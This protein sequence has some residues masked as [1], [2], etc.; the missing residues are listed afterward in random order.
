MEILIVDDTVENIKLVSDLLGDF[1]T[2]FARSG[3]EALKL[4]EEEH[5]DLILLDVMM[6]GLDGYETCQ[7]L[8]QMPNSAE[9]PVIF[10]T[11]KTDNE[12]IIKAFASGGQD[13]LSKPFHTEELRAR[14]K[15]QLISKRYQD[16]LKQQ[17]HLEK[18]KNRAQELNSELEGTL[19]QLQK[20]WQESFE[21]TNKAIQ[22]LKSD[23]SNLESELRV[24]SDAL[25]EFNKKIE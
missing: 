19:S 24:I 21:T 17:L 12:S 2:S 25:S 8:R 15:N 5:F 9:T 23:A 18:D 20:D 6:P 16:R 4:L 11:A 10:L 7:A 1:D 22:N 14:V 13:F 3:E